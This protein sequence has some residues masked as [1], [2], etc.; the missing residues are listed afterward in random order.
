MLLA[1]NSRSESVPC[2]L[3]RP[4]IS[5]SRKLIQLTIGVLSLSQKS[6]F[7][8]DGFPLV[9]VQRA[10]ARALEAKVEEELL[11]SAL[12][13]QWVLGQELGAAFNGLDRIPPSAGQQ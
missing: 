13:H 5:V 10:R 1:V 8:P 6:T 4:G 12:S 9:S 2:L 3:R 11:Q 7:S